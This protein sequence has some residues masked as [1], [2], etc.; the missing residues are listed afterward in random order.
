[1]CV[2]AAE[3]MHLD[4]KQEFL[5]VLVTDIDGAIHRYFRR[6]EAPAN[7]YELHEF[8][9]FALTSPKEIVMF[10]FESFATVAND[11]KSGNFT[12]SKLCINV[13]ALLFVTFFLMF[14]TLKSAR[15]RSFEKA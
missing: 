13:A 14:S 8:K 2:L 3:G 1:M 6:T 4:A 15:I 10:P 7:W 5:C 12:D 11:S 9:Q